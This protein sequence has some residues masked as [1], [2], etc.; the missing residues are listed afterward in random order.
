[1]AP[2][3]DLG[4]TTAELTS[5]KFKAV[6]G[7]RWRAVLAAHSTVDR[8]AHGAS[9]KPRHQCDRSTSRG[10]R[11]TWPIVHFEHPWL[12]DL[13]QLGDLSRSNVLPGKKV[14]DDPK[15]ALVVEFQ[16]HPAP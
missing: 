4:F 16:E 7:R 1:V 3:K 15:D 5:N 13:P 2:E 12:Q 9:R 6:C 10:L 8:W 14:I 11:P